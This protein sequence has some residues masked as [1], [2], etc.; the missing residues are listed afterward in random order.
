MNHQYLLLLLIAEERNITLPFFKSVIIM[1]T[2]YVVH[3]INI[4]KG[5]L[6]ESINIIKEIFKMQ[7]V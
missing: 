5:I 4:K 2:R 3:F 6:A 1:S 7:Q